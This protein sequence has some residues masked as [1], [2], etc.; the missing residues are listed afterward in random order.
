MKKINFMIPE[1]LQWSSINTKPIDLLKIV[2]DTTLTRD[3]SRW[4]FQEVK[5]CPDACSRFLSFLTCLE[6]R[7]TLSWH[8]RNIMRA[9][10]FDAS[11]LATTPT[12]TPLPSLA[13]SILRTSLCHRILCLTTNYDLK[14]FAWWCRH[15][16][17]AVFRGRQTLQ[18]SCFWWSSGAP[19]FR[20][21][22]S[23]IHYASSGGWERACLC[24]FSLLETNH[25]LNGGKKTNMKNKYSLDQKRTPDRSMYSTSTTYSQ[26]KM[27]IE[28]KRINVF[29]QN[30][31]FHTHYMHTSETDLLYFKFFMF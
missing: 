12:T 31:P 6:I 2:R 24:L 19:H 9:R 5:L 17:C 22:R 1:K 13:R 15:I 11:F 28:D 8:P 14:D 27:T 26:F 3:V 4:N 16:F 25:I 29:L 20:G 21:P 30:F 7:K 10:W 18:A 23:H